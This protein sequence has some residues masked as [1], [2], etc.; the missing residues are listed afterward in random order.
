MDNHRRIDARDVEA[1]NVSGSTAGASSGDFHV[2]RRQRRRELERLEQLQKDAQDCQILDSRLKAIQQLKA[3]DDQ[4]TAKRAARR[5]RKKDIRT[6]ARNNQD[7]LKHRV[8]SSKTT[9]PQ[10]LAQDNLPDVQLQPAKQH[11][12][13]HN[14]N[15]SERQTLPTKVIQPAH[16]EGTSHNSDSIR[17]NDALAEVCPDNFESRSEGHSATPAV[18]PQ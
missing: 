16:D 17:P 15:D 14:E 7:A 1:R 13:L 9:N 18:K 12:P 3:R 5:R 8:D 4:K 2:Y 6:L 10:Q 11:S